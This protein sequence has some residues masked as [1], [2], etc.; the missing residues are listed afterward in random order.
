MSASQRAL[1]IIQIYLI[2]V[3]LWWVLGVDFIAPQ[4][5]AV[6]LV[7]VNA[8][9]HPRFSPSDLALMDPLYALESQPM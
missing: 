8:D 2:G 6:L 1:Q 5:L 7:L 4:C 9:A 3:P